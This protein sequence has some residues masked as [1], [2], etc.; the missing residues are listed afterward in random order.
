M[1]GPRCAQVTTISKHSVV[2]GRY[3]NETA[4]PQPVRTR[5]P[6]FPPCAL[7]TVVPPT[8]IG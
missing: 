6:L 8:R 2:S 4:R 5:A 7:R 1:R 3:E